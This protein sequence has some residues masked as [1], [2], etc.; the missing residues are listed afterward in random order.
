MN[1]CGQN[2]SQLAASIDDLKIQLHLW[3]SST[4]VCTCKCNANKVTHE[5]AFLGKNYNANEGLAWESDVPATV[6]EI[7]VGDLP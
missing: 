5:L 4:E 6:D 3:F 2:Y 7:I 1:R